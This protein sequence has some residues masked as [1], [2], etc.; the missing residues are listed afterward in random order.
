MKKV[1]LTLFVLAG[2]AT[3]AIAQD[4][5]LIFYSPHVD[6]H[7]VDM[8]PAGL[9][10][11]DQYTRHGD[12]MS[13]SKGP[14]IGEYYSQATLIF[15][16]AAAKKSARTYRHEVILPGGTIYAWDVV[17]T[18]HGE[19]VRPGHMHEGAIIGGTGEYAGIRGTYKI[20]LMS[21]GDVFKTT[22]SYWLGQ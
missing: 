17:Q 20:E 10:I 21:S 11:G 16:D 15:L 6:P 1:L 13:D 18:D 5:S 2:F 8:A 14:S 7:Y 4:N 3:S 19:P 9:S 12:V 22:Y